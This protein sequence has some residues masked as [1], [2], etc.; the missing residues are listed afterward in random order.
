MFLSKTKKKSTT[1]AAVRSNSR[2]K[3]KAKKNGLISRLNWSRREAQLMVFVVVFAA[4]GG[5]YYAFR[6]FA[7]T[8]PFGK[9]ALQTTLP[10][11]KAPSDPN[12]NFAGADYDGDGKADIYAVKKLGGS[13]Q[14]EVHILGS[15]TNFRNFAAQVAT[16]LHRTNEGNWSFAAGDYDGDG[17]ADLINIQRQG[18]NNKTE[19]HILS[20]ASGFKTFVLHAALPIESTPNKN[21]W[22]FAA[23]DLDGDRKADLYAIKRNG[24]C[25]ATEVHVLSAASNY[26]RFIRQECTPLHH[27]HNANFQFSAGDYDNDGRADLYAVSMLGGSNTTE[28]HVLSAKSNFKSWIANRATALHR[29]DGNW[30]L[31]AGK[32]DGDS[33]ADLYTITTAGANSMEAHIL[34]TY[35]HVAQPPK[36][37]VNSTGGGSGGSG[38]SGST[39]SSGGHVGSI[40]GAVRNK[41]P[42][43]KCEDYNREKASQYAGKCVTTTSNKYYNYVLNQKG[44]AFCVKNFSAS[45]TA[46][47]RVQG[48]TVYGNDFRPFSLSFKEEHYLAGNKADLKPNT[49]A[50]CLS[51]TAGRHKLPAAVRVQ[52]SP[53]NSTIVF[54]LG[55]RDTHKT[56]YLPPV[57]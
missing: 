55:S 25:G 12:W 56:G 44:G 43:Q 34:G 11:A 14:T 19:V 7:N 51:N 52:P 39:G 54:W 47:V 17:R 21:E 32:Y 6:S 38:G 23:G 42:L 31:F 49:A 20:A 33:I 27:T 57:N 36:P 2:T 41:T 3:Q 37:S 45:A 24:G 13:G 4:L 26:S 1:K 8:A 18:A 15:R 53:A 40:D 5:G 50:F 16:G 30:T 10:I 9:F 29:T 35:A 48:A 22:S 46:K 28:V